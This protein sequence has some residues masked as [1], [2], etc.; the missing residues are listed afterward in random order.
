MLGGCLALLLGG[1]GAWLVFGRETTAAPCNGLPE[2]ERVR[3]SLGAALEPGMSCAEVGDAIV[4]ASAGSEPGRHTQQQAQVLKDVLFALEGGN[5]ENLAL[6]PALRAPL[7]TALADYAPDVHEMLAGL[8]SDYVTNAGRT[9]PPWEEGGTYHLA[10]P[11]TFF[12]DIVR[13]ISQDPT[14]YVTLRMAQTREGAR[15][16]AAVEAGATGADLSLPA[17]KNGRAL[18]FL[19]GIAATVSEDEGKGE[20]WRTAV[21]AG[22]LREPATEHRYQDDPAGHLVTAWLRDLKTTPTGERS[23][24][25]ATQ[26]V[27][28]AR[29]WTGARGTDEPTRQALLSE[30]EETRL[31][32]YRDVTR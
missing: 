17:L 16:L 1:V 7:A 6:D 22:L 14:A 5:P 26:A 28:M 9:N 21:V 20:A 30:V 31:S 8:D 2:H 32:V 12:G 10:V 23:D 11:H 27:D 13:A 3:T 24:R 29:T 15:R 4:R 19:D 18:G 25:L